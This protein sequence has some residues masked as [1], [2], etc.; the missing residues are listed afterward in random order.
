MDVFTAYTLLVPLFNFSSAWF[1]SR[2]N[3]PLQIGLYS[4]AF[5]LYATANSNRTSLCI[6]YRFDFGQCTR[7]HLKQQFFLLHK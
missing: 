5:A 6:Y 7:C 4:L 3:L 1:I 2:S